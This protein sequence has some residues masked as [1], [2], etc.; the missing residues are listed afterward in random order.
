[1]KK[2]IAAQAISEMDRVLAYFGDER[3][4]FSLSMINGSGSIGGT[5]NPKIRTRSAPQFNT[6]SFVPFWTM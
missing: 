3:I 1:M 6:R 2:N 5:V 4:G